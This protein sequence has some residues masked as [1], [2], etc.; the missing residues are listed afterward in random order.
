MAKTDGGLFSL[1]QKGTIGDA[2]TFTSYKGKS[3]VRV[4]SK[5]KQPRSGLQIG[6]RALTTWIASDFRNLFTFMQ[7]VWIEIAK[8]DDITPINAQIRDAQNRQKIGQGWRGWKLLDGFA[9][10]AP[11]ISDAIPSFRSMVLSWERPPSNQ[12]GFY[13]T[14]IYVSLQ[15]DVTGTLKELRLIVPVA[16]TE[17]QVLNL[18]SGTTVWIKVRETQYGGTLGDLSASMSVVIE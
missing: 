2:I 10:S 9:P 7:N 13:S 18:T 4:Q 12:R 14:A 17:V 16:T 5:R 15:D 11:T 1:D 3:Y 6:M 8:E